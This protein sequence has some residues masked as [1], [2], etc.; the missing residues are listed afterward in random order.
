MLG[1]C[2]TELGGVLGVLDSGWGVLREHAGLSLG[3]VLGRSVRFRL[4]VS[5][6][7]WGCVELSLKVWG[8]ILRLGVC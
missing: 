8:I 1:W 7:V 2:R 3:S 5:N 6:S 4:G